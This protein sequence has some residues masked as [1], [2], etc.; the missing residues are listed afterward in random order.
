MNKPTKSP[1][2]PPR[3]FAVILP[4]GKRPGLR[5][6]GELEPGTPYDRDAA[7]ALRLVRTKGFEFVN[8]ADRDAAEAIVNTTTEA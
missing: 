2:A 1:A 5:A 7:E 6:C 3:V 8:P 4:A